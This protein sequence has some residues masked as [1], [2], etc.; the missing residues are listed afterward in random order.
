MQALAGLLSV[1]LASVETGLIF[2]VLAIG[3]VMT[4][5]ILKISDLTVEGSFPLGAFI[6]AKF[7][8]L[9]RGPGLST[10][11]AF[12]FGLLAGLLTYLIYKKLKVDPL[13][14]GILTMTILY[15]VNLS[16]FGRANIPLNDLKTIFSVF[17]NV[18]PI[19]LLAI[20]LLIIKICT[21]GYLKSERGYLLIVTGDNPSLVRA[22][23]KN[24]DR[25]TRLGLMLSNGLIAMSGALMAQYQGFADSQ[26]GATMIVTGLASI[27]IGDTFLR[28]KN[29]SLT[30]RAILGA[31]IYRIITG[32]A[33]QAGLNPNYLK[34]VTAI[35]VIA[36]IAYN[37]ATS[38][39]KA[40]RR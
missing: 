12:T 33:L 5:K 16:I 28:S 40:K 21:D 1:L 19:L 26:M 31:I 29:I 30:T 4:Y 32:L 25:Y 9:G 10:L 13:L 20:I 3:V 7:A 15:S 14:A 39:K 23:G 8:T 2:S 35:I 36:F 18:K 22:L 17:P 11:M 37:N 34:A 38:S 24:P 6:F 27:I